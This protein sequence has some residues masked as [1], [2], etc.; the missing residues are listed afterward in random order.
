MLFKHSWSDTALIF[1][2][3]PN[4]LKSCNC[5]ICGIKRCMDIKMRTRCC[6]AV[7]TRICRAN[8]IIT[9]SAQ[10]QDRDRFTIILGYKVCSLS[11]FCLWFR[12]YANKIMQQTK[13]FLKQQASK[14][15]IQISLELT[16]GKMYIRLSF[17]NNLIKINYPVKKGEK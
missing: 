15:M 1:F 17:S 14:V 11:I 6:Y 8:H 5:A 16:K 4:C 9:T 10:L 3:P 13:Y 7:D 2:C 12:K